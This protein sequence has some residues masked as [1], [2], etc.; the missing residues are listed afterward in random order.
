MHTA[1]IS[2]AYFLYSISWYCLSLAIHLFTRYVSS[3]DKFNYF[4]SLQTLN[5]L[6]Y[7][8]FWHQYQHLQIALFL[9]LT[10]LGYRIGHRYLKIQKK[11]ST[12]T[13]RTNVILPSCFCLSPKTSN[14]FR[15][16]QYNVKNCECSMHLLVYFLKKQ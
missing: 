4:F 6:V 12:C 8:R 13:N 2:S 15:W 14:I 7:C 5:S 1:N 11:V 3:W 16:L 10:H 9:V